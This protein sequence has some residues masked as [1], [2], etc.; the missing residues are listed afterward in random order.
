VT[1]ATSSAEPFI[2]SPDVVAGPA[3]STAV[4]T[5]RPP[6][7]PDQPAVRPATPDPA[8][9]LA[10]L[11]ALSTTATYMPGAP[12]PPPAPIGP[13]PAAQL[14]APPVPFSSAP[15]QWELAAEP[16][17]PVAAAAVPPAAPAV[18]VAAPV[19]PVV[20]EQV[21]ADEVVVDDEVVARDRGQLEDLAEQLA[22]AGLSVQ[23]HTGNIVGRFPWL[24]IYCPQTQRQAGLFPACGVFLYVTGTSSPRRLAADEV[25]EAVVGDINQAGGPSTEPMPAV[26][27]LPIPPS[28][29]PPPRPPVPSMAAPAPA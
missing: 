20:A 10:R 15:A 13:P 22:R 18:D 2:S 14:A 28:M 24:G 9:A 8:A 26:P 4:D 1:A 17:P 5:A 7:Y 16:H 25:A 23:V 12:F 6:A 29:P 11:A 3:D 21:P 19:D 27:A